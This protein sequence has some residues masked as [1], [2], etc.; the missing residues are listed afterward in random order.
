MK[1]SIPTGKIPPVEVQLLKGMTVRDIDDMMKIKQQ[2]SV[3]CNLCNY[4]D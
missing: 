2:F 3:W 4:S 1:F